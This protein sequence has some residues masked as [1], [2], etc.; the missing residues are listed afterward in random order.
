MQIYEKIKKELLAHGD[1]ENILETLGKGFSPLSVSGVSA[2]HKAQMALLVSDRVCAGAPLLVIAEDDAGAKRLCDDINEMAGDIACLYPAKD[3]TL[4][5]V[6]RSS[7][8]YE[9]Q[10]LCALTRAPAVSYALRQ[11]LLCR[12]LCRRRS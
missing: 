7:K 5:R 8:E 2:V 9:Y 11:R 3:L 12:K 10:R 6:D 4:A 1:I